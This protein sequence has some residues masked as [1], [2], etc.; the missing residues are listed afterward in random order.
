MKQAVEDF[1]SLAVLIYPDILLG[2][3]YTTTHY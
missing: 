1:R 2:L 3:T